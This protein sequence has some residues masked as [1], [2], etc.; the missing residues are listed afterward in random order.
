MLLPLLSKPTHACFQVDEKTRVQKTLKSPIEI[1]GIGLFSGHPVQLQIKPAPANHGIV[2]V[3]TD[4]AGSLSIPALSSYVVATPRCTVLGRDGV[5][6][7]TV[8]HL[9]AALCAFEIDNA[10]IEINGPEVPVLDGSSLPFVRLIKQAGI[11]QQ[12]TPKT[13][14]RLVEPLYYSEK[15]TH[16]VAIPSN[17]FKVSFTLQFPAVYSIATQYASFSLSPE[18]FEKEIAP[19]RTFSAYEEI[20]PLIEKGLIKGGSLEN[21]VLI[22][23]GEVLNP[24][25][26]RM[27]DEFVRHKILDVIGDLSLVGFTFLA[28]V[29]AIRSGHASNFAFAKI[30]ENNFKMEIT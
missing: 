16:I 6:I 24:E 14:Y 7:Q 30:L 28:H 10:L 19:A 12:E 1:A 23:G 13:I 20:A 22:Q 21:A 11:V 2:F 3:R 18:I 25:G 17:E 27:A 29:I 8:E 4:L 9:L 26:V 15:E 5:V